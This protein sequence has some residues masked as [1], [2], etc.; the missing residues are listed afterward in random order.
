MNKN[1][2]M[3][4]LLYRSF[5]DRLK[6]KEQQILTQALENSPGLHQEKEQIQA[7]RNAA[8][9]TAAQ[10]FKPFF[11]ERVMEQVNGLGGKTNGLG[12][13]M[14]YESLVSVFR[15]F[16]VVGAVISVLL[17]IYN[18]GMGEILPLEEALTMS[19]LT[20]QEILA[21]F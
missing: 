5:D 19:D 1:K 20:L 9:N 13:Q 10:S 8:A 16:A 14:F 7:Q 17:F 18:Q 3:L 6:E 4:K 2:K 12:M 11:V 15:R 21:M